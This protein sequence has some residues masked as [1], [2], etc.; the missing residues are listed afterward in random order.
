MSRLSPSVIKEI[1]G[2]IAAGNACYV[3]KQSGEITIID[4][5]TEDAKTIA[6][7]AQ[8]QIELE[9]E[10]ENYIVIKKIPTKARLEIMRAFLVEVEDKS[11]RKQLSN[12]LN[13][14]NPVR[15]FNQSIEGNL[16]L[17]QHWRNF[18]MEESEYWISGFVGG[19]KIVRIINN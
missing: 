4:K 15:N 9:K 3:H 1:A 17:N 14:K 19:S 18:D 7:Q 16:E 2:E 8:Q 13:R 10:I 12:A 6:A 11:V 5:S